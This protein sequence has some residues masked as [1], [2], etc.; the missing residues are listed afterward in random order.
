MVRSAR[1][2]L[3][4]RTGNVERRT[5]TVVAAPPAGGHAPTLS[6]AAPEQPAHTPAEHSFLC[7]GAA[8][9][10]SR[11]PKGCGREVRG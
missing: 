2:L 5:D 6:K 3:P 4:F 11:L 1:R 9:S 7:P 10:R 8:L